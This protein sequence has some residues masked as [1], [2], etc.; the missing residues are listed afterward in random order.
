MNTF[1][2]KDYAIIAA[3]KRDEI[4]GKYKPLIHIAWQALGGR[5]KFSFSLPERCATFQEASALAL[6]AAKKWT[7]NQ[8]EPS[9]AIVLASRG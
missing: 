8:P 9:E 2:Y 3:A 7:N 4:T 6:D 1:R 5:R